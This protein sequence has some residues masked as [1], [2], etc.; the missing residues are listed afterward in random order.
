MCYKRNSRFSHNCNNCANVTFN[1]CD[2]EQNCNNVQNYNF[3]DNMDDC[4]CGF[5]E[6]FDVFPENP[7]YG[8]SYVPIQVMN[9]VFKPAVGLKNGTIF[10]ELVSPYCPNQSIEEIEYIRATNSIGEGCNG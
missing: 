2:I 4:M 1:K 9:Q 5:D 7:M 10:P 3:N 6:E 8:Q